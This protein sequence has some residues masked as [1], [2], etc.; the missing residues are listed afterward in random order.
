[1]FTQAWNKYLPVIRILMK[2]S[3]NGPQKLD[4]NRTDFERAAGGRKLKFTFSTVTLTRVVCRPILPHL[5][6]RVTWCWY[7]NRMRLPANLSGTRNSNSTWIP[8]SSSPSKISRPLLKHRLAMRK[9][10]KKHSPRQK[11]SCLNF[12]KTGI[13]RFGGNQA[14]CFAGLP[15]GFF[16]LF[17]KA[18]SIAALRLAKVGRR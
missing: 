6:W 2:R 14:L 9:N 17:F 12:Y 15:A 18:A 8:F 4:T 5:P 13:N 16:L 3:V 1:M 7:Y 10:R 11:N